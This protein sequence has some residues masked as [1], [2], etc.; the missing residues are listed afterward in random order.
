MEENRTKYLLKNTA[1]FAMGSIGTKIITF[2]LVPLY[3]NLLPV[4][5]Y[6]VVD[7]ITTTSTVLAPMLLLNI[8]EA[9]MRFSLDE[10]ANTNEIMS[11]GVAVFGVSLLAGLLLIPAAAAF[12]TISEYAVCLYFYTVSLAG[13]Q[14]LLSYL[15]GTEKLVQFSVGNILHALAVACFNILL[16]LFLKKG[17]KGYFTAY[18]AA[19]AV[20]ILYAFAAGKVWEP[21]RKFRI[22][23]VLAKE[24][25]KYSVVLIPNTFMWWIMNSSDRIMVTAMVGAAA[26][27]I[28]AI[29]YKVP[30][31]MQSITGIFNQAWSYSAIRENSSEDRE[32]Y[33]NSVFNGIVAMSTIT[34]VGLLAIM[35]PFLR[36]YVEKAYYPAW[37][38]TP[39]L[40]VG[41]VFLAL[42]S[43]LSSYYTVNKDSKGFLFSGLTGAVV[44]L[45]LNALLIPLLGVI[46]AALA[47]CVSYSMVY[48]YRIFDTKKYIKLC[49]GRVQHLASYG[50]L[51]LAALT[52]FW[53]NA[54]GQTVQF[55]ELAAIL[56]INWKTFV[57]MLNGIRRKHK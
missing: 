1:V 38:Y 27:G 14:L 21:I 25:A 5:E 57:P 20:T 39:F 35:K 19:N 17:I 30:S 9:V 12:P 22:N 47:T 50:V 43:F 51:L 56:L 33:G 37:R 3:T 42:G 7:L 40:I 54:L 13:S 4:Y 8:N 53:D 32:A 49:F 44:N 31:L 48:V 16:L 11:I 6:G 28:Y 26:N 34:G 55:V 45:I 15:R 36:F 10:N 2:F 46:G 52:M 24:M 23:P 41:S 18:I 29:S